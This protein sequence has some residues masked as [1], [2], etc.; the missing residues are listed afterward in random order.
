MGFAVAV[1]AAAAGPVGIGEFADGALDAGP[2]GI[3]PFPVEILLVGAVVGLEFV[4][5]AGEEV[6][7]AGGLSPCVSRPVHTRIA[8]TGGETGDCVGVMAGASTQVV[9]V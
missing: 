1:V 6:H 9:L 5:V 3:E 2:G 8:L 7:A 4:Q